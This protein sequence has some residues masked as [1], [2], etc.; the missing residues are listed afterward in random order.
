MEADADEAASGARSLFEPVHKRIAQEM[1]RSINVAADFEDS[2]ARA[3]ESS[4]RR[5]WVAIKLVRLFECHHWIARNRNVSLYARRAPSCPT[6]TR[7]FIYRRIFL[8]S[9]QLIPYYFLVVHVRTTSPS[10]S[11]MLS[12][13]VRHLQCKTWPTYAS[14]SSISIVFVFVRENEMCALSWTPN[15]VGTR[16]VRLVTLPR[17]LSY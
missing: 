6:R 5:T 15:I 2:R 9:M 10:S 8:R 16:R 4:G 13:L 3:D 14:C 1:I 12:R 11:R 7:Y 17:L